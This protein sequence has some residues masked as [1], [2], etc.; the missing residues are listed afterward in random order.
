MFAT[1]DPR[2]V[3]RECRLSFAAVLKP[4]RSLSAHMQNVRK[5]PSKWSFRTPK[6]TPESGHWWDSRS[7]SVSAGNAALLEE[8][9]LL[10]L[11][12]IVHLKVWVRGPLMLLGYRPPEHCGI[13][14]AQ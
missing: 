2:I 8:L 7:A 3:S 12:E 11:W 5:A 10:D 14:M 4:D 1:A 9:L 13:P 6:L